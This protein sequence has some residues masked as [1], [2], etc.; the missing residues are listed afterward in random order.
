MLPG[1][2]PVPA[3]S[4][5]CSNSEDHEL[6]EVTAHWPLTVV[7]ADTVVVCTETWVTV[8][9]ETSV[10]VFTIAGMVNSN[11]PTSVLRW[12]ACR[13]KHSHT[14]YTL[15]WCNGKGNTILQT[16]RNGDL[17]TKDQQTSSE[18]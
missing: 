3:L 14:E 16:L 17:R 8:T 13:S 5:N 1:L 6:T 2:R 11:D 4:E 15:S 10:V 9:I 7:N 18:A 12:S